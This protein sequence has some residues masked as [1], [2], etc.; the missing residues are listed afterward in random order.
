MKRRMTGLDS[1]E[2]D[3]YFGQIFLMISGD[4][5][6]RTPNIS[7]ATS[8][9][10]QPQVLTQTLGPTFPT[11]TLLV[12]R[13]LVLGHGAEPLDPEFERSQGWA[14]RC[15][16]HKVWMASDGSEVYLFRFNLII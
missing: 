11:L 15:L 5:E 16:Q 7:R 12:P 3:G 2:L 6:V 8:W 10:V 1:D 9:G 13:Q 4:V 14:R